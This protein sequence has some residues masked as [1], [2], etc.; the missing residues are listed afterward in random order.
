MKHN[1]SAL[2]LPSESVEQQ[3]L[4][5]WAELHTGKYPELSL[6]FHIPNEGKRSL[7]TGGR[8]KA[9]GLKPGVPDIC[10]PVPRGPYHGLYIEMKAGRNR[11]TENQKWWLNRL[12]WQG[13]QTAVCYSCEEAAEC[14]KKYLGGT[15]K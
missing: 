10:L 4:F 11:V 7:A 9:E 12:S 15:N 8:L 1:P 5:R 14:I 6:M 2:P 13:Y 3:C